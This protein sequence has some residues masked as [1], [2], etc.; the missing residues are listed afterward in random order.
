[1]DFTLGYLR[2][3]LSNYDRSSVCNRITN[4]LTNGKFHT[5]L[6]FVRILEED[7]IQFLN[8][9]LPDEIKYAFNEQD[10]IRGNQ[11]NEVYELLI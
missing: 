7:E 4:K 6:D 11:L 8:N 2:E 10:F 3:A 9:V 1:M 5:E